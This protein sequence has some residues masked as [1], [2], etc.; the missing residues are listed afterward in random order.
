MQQ[1]APDVAASPELPTL[2][3]TAQP[4][5]EQLQVWWEAMQ[6]DNLSVAYADSF[7]STLTDFRL[8]VAQGE[9]L[10][11]LC[12]VA[13]CVAGALWL[14]DMQHRPD[15]TVAAGWLG[16]YF[17]PSYRGRLAAQLLRTARQRW[18]AAGIAHL[19]S[20]VHISNRLSQAFL[21][22]G[23]S[24]HRVG[25]FPRFTMFHGQPVD[26]VIYTQRAED[27]RLAW[28]LAAARAARQML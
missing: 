18:D 15:G 21:T 11:L 14:H 20:A 9:K 13:D 2:T 25:R 8:E 12:L 1:T 5:I 16:G 19:F 7:P 10:L 6:G 26:V 24:F 27:T 22:R 23:A 3:V 4:T 28:E 17:L